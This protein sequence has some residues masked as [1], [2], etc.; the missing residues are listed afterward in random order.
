MRTL[1]LALVLSQGFGSLDQIPSR[2]K[3]HVSFVAEQQVIPAGKKARLELRFRVEDGFHVNS[4]TPK[5]ELLTPTGVEFEP[6]SG[7]KLAAAEYPAGKPYSFSFEPREKLDVYTDGFTVK[8][9]LVAA[10]GAHELKGT[11]S[12]QS[13]D[14]AACYPPRSLPVTVVFTAK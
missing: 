5:S 12:Y 13:C 2:S 11:L 4:H 6:A 1:L 7:V 14:K 8:L 3:Q 9:P 10:A